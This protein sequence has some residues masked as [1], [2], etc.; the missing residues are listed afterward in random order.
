MNR[1]YSAS[2]VATICLVASPWT[3][4]ANGQEKKLVDVV[5]IYAADGYHEYAKDGAATLGLI[6]QRMAA[7]RV[8]FT[9]C[10]NKTV[11]VL[12]ADLRASK[13]TCERKQRVPGIWQ[14]NELAPIY[15][16]PADPTNTKVVFRDQVIDL[17]SF[18]AWEGLGIKLPPVMAG[19][20]VGF[21]FKDVNGA[22]AM[23]ILR[24][25]SRD[26]SYK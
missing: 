21:V 9:M 16:H 13:A 11:E 19:E 14:T 6:T 22:D 4:S 3:T 1:Y 17:K 18:K 2:L 15:K 26:G 12:L 24:D 8:K 5:A 7:G 23:A 25:G 20:P 10:D